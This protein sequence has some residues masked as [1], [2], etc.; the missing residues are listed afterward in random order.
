MLGTWPLHLHALLQLPAPVIV[1]GAGARG[2]ILLERSADSGACSTEGAAP[3]NDVLEH[4]WQELDECSRADL[5]CCTADGAQ[6]GYVGRWM[7]TVQLQ[8]VNMQLD[9]NSHIACHVRQAPHAICAGLVPLWSDLAASLERAAQTMF[10][11][12]GSS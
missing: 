3:L 2:S 1:C 5:G 11:W 12:A 6:I 8:H 9:V 4:L 7:K 10:L